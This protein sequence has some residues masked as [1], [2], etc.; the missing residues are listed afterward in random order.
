MAS[1]PKYRRIN[2]MKE[3]PHDVRPGDWVITEDGES[4]FFDRYSVTKDWGYFYDEDHR[5]VGWPDQKTKTDHLAFKLPLM[6]SKPSAESTRKNR[7]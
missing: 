4:L 5:S 1:R 2:A 3:H 7:R 6:G